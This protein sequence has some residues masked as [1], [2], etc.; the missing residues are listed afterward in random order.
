MLPD[1]SFPLF[2]S[3]FLMEMRFPT[4][5]LPII[6]C[7]VR[8]FVNSSPPPLAP[9]TR[10]EVPHGPTNISFC[11]ALPLALSGK[12]FLS[13]RLFR[14]LS[15]GLLPPV[16]R[17]GF[18]HFT[19]RS[20][21]HPRLV[22]PFPTPPQTSPPFFFPVINVFGFSLWFVKVPRT[23]LMTHSMFQFFF[24]VIDVGSSAFCLAAATC[25][26]LFPAP[27]LVF[28]SGWF[29]LLGPVITYAT[30]PFGYTG[31]PQSMSVF[32]T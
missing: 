28:L 27:L 20:N 19:R 26:E 23:N 10:T 13:H 3:P 6:C 24:P 9:S 4:T 21:T 12:G 7:T 17:S 2:H 16:F 22:P 5:P 1:S 8:V 29:V 18:A 32:L 14:S 25:S 11:L 15:S 30:P 31:P